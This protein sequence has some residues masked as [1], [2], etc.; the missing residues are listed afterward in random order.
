MLGRLRDEAGTEPTQS[1]REEIGEQESFVT[2]LTSLADDIERI[3]SIWNP[4]FSD[5]VIIN[6][7]PLWRLVPQ[8]KGWQR[9]CKECWD[10]LVAGEYDWAHLAM[11]L[12][13]ERVTPK[14]AN[15]CSLA[16]AHGLEDLFW[17]KEDEKWRGLLA[18]SSEIGNQKKRRMT[19]VREQFL[20]A[21][22]ALAMSEIGA[23][24]TSSVWQSL[25]D[26][27]LDG[28]KAA[29]WVW[30]DRVIE[31][32][33]HDQ[34]MADVHEIKQREIESSRAC[35]QLKRRY[36]TVELEQLRAAAESFCVGRDSA[37]RAAWEALSC[38]DFDEQAL[39]LELWPDRVIEKCLQDVC[40][41]EKH[42]LRDY[43]WYQAPDN[44]WR[45]RQEP[46]EEVAWESGRRYNRTV[47]DALEKFLAAPSPD[48]GNKRRRTKA[49]KSSAIVDDAPTI[50]RGKR[51]TKG[52][53]VHNETGELF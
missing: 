22:A 24:T 9:E 31:R 15:D 2:E 12:W 7:A 8:H 37:F 16:I 42:R 5:G 45:R 43:F 51:K 11:H 34:T 44:G 41:A 38:G 53:K 46:D 13:P 47:K 25:R 35:A 40:L 30:P 33:R 20:K 17:I 18:P 14:C 4:H 50:A 23:R 6:F 39:A 28:Q 26:G 10:S 48:G 52:T 32:A 3:A 27:E 1:Q 21:L 36:N 49:A 29:L 19:A